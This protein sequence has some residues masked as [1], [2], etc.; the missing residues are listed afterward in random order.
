MGAVWDFLAW[1]SPKTPEKDRLQARWLAGLSLA[2][3]LIGSFSV[4][5]ED[6][7][8][9]EDTFYQG[10]N[11]I[12]VFSNFL[13]V[14]FLFF[15][16]R[17]G[18]YKIA[19]RAFVV[20][21]SVT[22]FAF[23]FPGDA[24]R[25][26]DVL[27][28]LLVA[29]V[30]CRLFLSSRFTLMLIFSHLV[31]MLALNTF[32]PGNSLDE[33]PAVAV[34]AGSLLILLTFHLRSLADAQKSQTAQKELTNYANR[35][36]T[37]RQIEQ[38]ILAAGSLETTAAAALEHLQ[39]VLPHQ[40][41]SILLIDWEN[42][43]AIIQATG[44]DQKS[45]ITTGG[46]LPLASLNSIETL[47]ANERFY[48]I[49]NLPNY[50]G[51]S[52]LQTE[53]V[54]SGIHSI[55][56]VPL[57]LK[58]GLIGSLNIADKT[59]DAYTNQHIEI[60]EEIA[61]Q[62]A[63]ALKQTQ[64]IEE[65]EQRANELEA[66]RQASISLISSA[67]LD[68]VLMAVLEATLSLNPAAQHARIFL[69]ENQQI[70]KSTSLE[71]NGVIP[72]GIPDPRPNGITI[73][74][75]R[76]GEAA[77]IPDV[78]NDPDFRPKHDHWEGALVCMPLKIGSRVVGVMNIKYLKPRRF[79]QKELRLI[80]LLG[81]Q[82]A[83]AIENARLYDAERVARIRT[84]S[85]LQV[86]RAAAS[87]VSLKEILNNVL[88]QCE[89][90]VPFIS[91]SIL[92]FEEEIPAVMAFRGH[93][94]KER[95]V[96]DLLN[97]LK[98]SPILKYI[99]RTRKA[100]FISDTFEEGD[101]IKTPKGKHIRSWLGV[102]IVARG[103]TIGLISLDSDEAHTFNL[104]HLK[105]VQALADEIGVVIQNARLYEQV[106]MHA[107]EL[108]DRVWQRTQELEKSYNEMEAFAY[109]MAHDLRAPLRATEGFSNALLEDFGEQLGPEGQ[110][111]TQRILNA[112]HRMDELI[113]DLLEYSRL[114]RADMHLQVVDLREIV[115]EAHT[116]LE[117]NIE[118]SQ[119]EIEIKL[120][121]FAVLAHPLTM[122]QVVTNL[123]SNAIKFVEVDTK[124]LV[125]LVTRSN[126]NNVRLEVS[127]N[128]IGIQEE[129]RERIFKIFER[130]HGIENYPGTGI[131][132]A[133]VHRGMERMQGQVG[134]ES[135]K[136]EGSI[137]WVELP[138]AEA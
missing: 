45:I 76:Q 99:R 116:N 60:A 37:L 96:E 61:N 122:L 57:T 67:E 98:T 16:N 84:D 90:L 95:R 74:V 93:K 111:Y 83:I 47:L 130:L 113:G 137:F 68:A 97:L 88:E 2:V 127:D 69:F 102:P 132:L 14:V 92:I 39:D 51:K 10:N 9:S 21:I 121:E 41:S 24:A 8:F 38:D 117:K 26:S 13:L 35:L 44:G 119:A 50:P 64:L 100:R 124:P 109:S 110:E 19:V 54:R 106:Q 112:A 7:L 87:E 81:D 12:I 126:G 32:L 94:S 78:Q 4:I 135:K 101:W 25:D 20:L 22:I 3:I 15:L 66:V 49:K 79:E 75:A 58:G 28:Y 120:D 89:E 17:W 129:H 91:G 104:E 18:H 42:M 34:T 123:L 55:L 73:R 138:K 85:L 36:N 46:R 72:T 65:T 71:P 31:G 82:A 77:I 128:G 52:A 40:R 11:R 33:N 118:D 27:N 56:S 115:Q 70:S 114:S 108:E 48:L 5:A 133:I 1:V 125:R 63:L 62:L 103:E 134:F 43:E 30:F 131:G 105:W 6:L 80:K 86:V 23:A 59:P 29:V 136:G 107:A 53:M